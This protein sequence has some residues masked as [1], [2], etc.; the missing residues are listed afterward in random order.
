MYGNLVYL[1]SGPLVVTATYLF[2][3]SFG[4]PLRCLS[5]SSALVALY[6][7]GPH[8]DVIQ[9]EGQE[10]VKLAVAVPIPVRPNC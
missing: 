9:W 3:H 7:Y 10:G 6:N 5:S 8:L 2:I 1:A 4:R